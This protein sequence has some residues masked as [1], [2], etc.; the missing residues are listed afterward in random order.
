MAKRMKALQLD[1]FHHD[2]V[3]SLLTD[4]FP[5]V[6]MKLAS[7]VRVLKNGPKLIGYQIV[8]RINAPDSREL[9]AFLAA[10]KSFPKVKQLEVWAKKASTAYALLAVSS[11]T[12]TYEEIVENG[13]MH[14]APVMMSKGFDIHSIVTTDFSRLKSLLNELEEIGELKIKRIG[15][16]NP[17][18]NDELLTEKQVDAL[19]KAISFEYYSW[20]RKATLSELA[21]HCNM[22]RRAYQEHLRK[23][24]A[25]L[26]PEMLK[27]YLMTKSAL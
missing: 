12:S 5:E 27:E 24:E 25:K 2:C 21:G 10:L 20:P 15:T 26:F 7:T 19:R 11:P 6:S 1:I 23:A 17:V 13:G 18:L 14:F 9:E 16:I 4:R 8:V 3:A 22:S